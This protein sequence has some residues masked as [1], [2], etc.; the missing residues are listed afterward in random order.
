MPWGLDEGI[1]KNA[2]RVV[3]ALWSSILP[4]GRSNSAHPS[5][6]APGIGVHRQLFGVSFAE[7]AAHCR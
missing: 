4:D 5:E 3:T 2:Q 1:E 6:S 7:R